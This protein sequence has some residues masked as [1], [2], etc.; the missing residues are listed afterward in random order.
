MELISSDLVS[1]LYS[2]ELECSKGKA[3]Q[4]HD[5]T[6]Y[7]TSSVWALITEVLGILVFGCIDC[8]Y[9]VLFL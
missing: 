7:E 5:I 6:L 3:S 1:I 4:H 8:I 2:A 9:T